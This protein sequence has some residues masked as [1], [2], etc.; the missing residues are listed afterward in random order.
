M[1]TAELT[2]VGFAGEI[3]LAWNELQSSLHGCWKIV[4]GTPD[5]QS[6]ANYI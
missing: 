4:C 2:S 5:A 1:L 6:L 3:Q